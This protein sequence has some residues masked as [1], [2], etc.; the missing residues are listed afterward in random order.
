MSQN[1]IVKSI[2]SLSELTEVK[3]AE[4]V[5]SQFRTGLRK[6]MQILYT[7]EPS[8]IRCIKSNHSKRSSI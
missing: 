3:K 6:L 7:K 8:Y 4:T 5:G 2:Y 1:S